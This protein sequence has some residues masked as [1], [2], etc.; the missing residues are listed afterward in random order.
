MEYTRRVQ[1]IDEFFAGRRVGTI[2]QPEVD[3][4]VVHRL[5]EGVVA[6]T[7]RRELGTL[8]KMLR[9]AY[10]NKKLL[11]LPMLEK[12]KEGPAR[13]GFFERDQ[14]AA[15]RRQLPA[16]LQ[17]AAVI[18]YV[19]GWRMQSEVLA[20]ERRHVNLAAGTLRLDTSK[21]GEGREVTMT[22]EVRALLTQQLAR[23]DGLQRE[24][25]RIVPWVFPHLSGPKRQGTR[26]QDFR[27]VW[28]RARKAAGCSGM[29]RHD[30]RRTAVRNMVNAGVAERVAMTLTGH[31]TGSVFDRYHM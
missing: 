10:K 13:T 3:A 5:G 14:F 20:L 8:T 19:Y 26:I 17:V 23:V 15:V 4:Y 31:K 11:R 22:A 9:L 7:I 6:S 30:F 1:H 25:K 29:H 27:K 28:T 24:L 12:P 2:G 18:A 21:N 16:D